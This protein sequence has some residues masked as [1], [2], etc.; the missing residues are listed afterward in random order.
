MGQQKGKTK[1][2]TCLYLGTPNMAVLAMFGGTLRQ[3]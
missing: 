2:K 3:N 1:N